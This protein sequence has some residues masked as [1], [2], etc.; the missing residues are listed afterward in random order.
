MKLIEPC[1][2]QRL[3]SKST[4]E[5]KHEIVLEV[6]GKYTNNTTDDIWDG[7][8]FLENATQIKDREVPYEC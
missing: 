6:I 3:P 8:R 4:V 5:G 1:K 2:D 7:G